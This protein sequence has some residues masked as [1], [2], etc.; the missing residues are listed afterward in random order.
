M[1]WEHYLANK[2]PTSLACNPVQV[3]ATIL[4]SPKNNN[5]FQNHQIFFLSPD[6]LNFP[7]FPWH[8]FCKAANVMRKIEAEVKTKM[9]GTF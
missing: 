3:F 4:E 9:E 7:K 8:G 6:P 5:L 2:E 1:F